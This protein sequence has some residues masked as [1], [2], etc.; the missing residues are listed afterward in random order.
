MKTSKKHLFIFNGLLLVV[1]FFLIQYSVV[2]EEVE[3]SMPPVAAEFEPVLNGRFAE[4]VTVFDEPRAMPD[5]SYQTVLG[6]TVNLDDLKGQWV[7]FNL[8]ATWCPPCLVEMPSLQAAQDKFGGQGI[9]I[10]AVALDRNMNSETLKSF[11]KKQNFGPVAA[12]YDENNEIMRSL[13]IRGLPTTYILAPNGRAVA[14]MEGDADWMS[15]DGQAFLNS[16]TGA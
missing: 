12:Y 9:Q 16:L 1:A 5:I 14:L 4:A 2:N 3:E 11:M 7:V 8:W 15:D 6:E 13:N 10:I